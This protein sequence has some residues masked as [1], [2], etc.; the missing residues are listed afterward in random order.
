MTK[1]V[2]ILRHGQ[3]IICGV[4]RKKSICIHAYKDFNIMHMLCLELPHLYVMP[5][6]QANT[7]KI[8]QLF[9]G[10]SSIVEHPF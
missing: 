2:V 1:R 10:H 6:S 5:L 8:P 4:G 7:D 9:L 3:Y